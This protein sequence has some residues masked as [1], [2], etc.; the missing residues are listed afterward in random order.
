M[1]ILTDVQDDLAELFAGDEMGKTVIYTP[2]GGSPVTCSGIVSYGEDLDDAQWR[3]AVQSS[4]VLWI[5][6]DDLA[7][8]TYQDTVE[9]D[10]ATWTVA[11]KLGESPAALKFEIRRDLAP[12]FRGR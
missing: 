6:R 11:K 5:K 8:W 2:S 7:S 4:A 10:G 12:T 3:A 1:S 9:I